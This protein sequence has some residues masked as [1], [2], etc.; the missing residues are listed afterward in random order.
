MIRDWEIPSTGSSLYSFVGLVMFYH[1]YAPY[2][3]MRIKPLR[4]L[5]KLYFRT[6]IPVMAW[7]Q[8]SLELFND[9]KICI[10]SSPVLARY[11]PAKPTF[12]KTD[13]SAEGMGWIMMQPA[14]DD[15]SIAA[16]K[17]LLETGECL[18]D[19]TKN[20]ARLRPTGFGSRACL[21]QESKYHSFVGEA[22]C[23][24]W[25]IGQNRKYL[26]GVRFWWMCD[27][28]AVREILEYSG[29]IDMICRWAQELL[30]YHLLE[31]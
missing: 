7:T 10:T 11:D 27:C 17:I 31:Y 3:E 24:R 18:F 14:D 9:I 6:Q 29:V 28:K 12:L 30:G 20:G 4:R 21:P 2:L 5:I 26:W 1:R 25:A 23:G 22:A 19:L 15:E 8:E 16:T 13:W